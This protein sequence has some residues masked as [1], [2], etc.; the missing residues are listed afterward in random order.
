MLETFGGQE[1]NAGRDFDDFARAFIDCFALR[2]YE[3][4]GL[5]RALAAE[6]VHDPELRSKRQWLDRE[7]LRRALSLV[8][9]FEA[10]LDVEATEANIH[11]ALPAISA[12]FRGVADSSDE[13]G[14]DAP[15]AR[16]RL[17]R[18]LTNQLLG[19]VVRREPSISQA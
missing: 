14:F 2:W 18:A 12:A 13:L 1:A 6:G 16:E 9:G 19:F 5:I 7:I 17:V 15:N 8:G 11:D 4:S 3:E 10:D